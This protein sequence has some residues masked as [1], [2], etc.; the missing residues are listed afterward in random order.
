M[1]TDERGNGN[2][3]GTCKV[4]IKNRL[5]GLY[6]LRFGRFSTLTEGQKKRNGIYRMG[7]GISEGLWYNEPY[8]ENC[9]TL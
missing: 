2:R 5:S 4:Q 1:Q 9:S 6:L 3:S 8:P 7:I